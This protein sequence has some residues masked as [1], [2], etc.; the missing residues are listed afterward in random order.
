ML[1][2]LYQWSGYSNIIEF[3]QILNKHYLC[4][5]SKGKISLEYIAFTIKS[6]DC[7]YSLNLK[8]TCK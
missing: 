4:L 3:D 5:L 6:G 1:L 8:I 2:V 7:F